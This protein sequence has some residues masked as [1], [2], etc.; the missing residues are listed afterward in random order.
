MLSPTPA[1]PKTPLTPKAPPPRGTRAPAATG[2][3]EA[4]GTESSEGAEVAEKHRPRPPAR[5]PPTTAADASNPSSSSSP[6]AADGGALLVVG[7]GG[8]SS[9]RDAVAVGGVNESPLHDV[10]LYRGLLEALPTSTAI[11]SVLFSHRGAILAD[12]ETPD[13]ALTKMDD[14]IEKWRSEK[15][16]ELDALYATHARDSA[17][18]AEVTLG[19]IRAGDERREA[20]VH[21]LM[22]RLEALES[23][24]KKDV[25][26]V[27]SKHEIRKANN[28]CAS[29]SPSAVNPNGSADDSCANNNDGDAEKSGLLGGRGS[30]TAADGGPPENSPFRHEWELLQIRKKERNEAAQKECEQID[31]TEASKA[32]ARAALSVA[33]D[34]AKIGI[35]EQLTR[36]G[37]FSAQ[38]SERLLLRRE[39]GEERERLRAAADAVAYLQTAVVESEVAAFAKLLE[40]FSSSLPHQ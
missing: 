40:A 35:N 12:A 39:M 37:V 26:R 7:G 38:E 5:A 30:L 6:A 15:K 29:S 21:D 27:V 32:A 20:K 18:E 36:C 8:S 19:R 10:A 16:A 2:G 4:D 22:L 33:A 11:D 24:V 23:A 34:A 28:S 13:E 3:R 14:R 17:F 25:E 31:T 9:G 1:P